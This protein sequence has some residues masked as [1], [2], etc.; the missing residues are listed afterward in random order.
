MMFFVKIFSFRFVHIAHKC[1]I[2]I[3]PPVIFGVA[4]PGQV[5]YF[6]TIKQFSACRFCLLSC[7]LSVD[8]EYNDIPVTFPP[9]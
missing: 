9:T 4:I 1:K 5:E 8:F 2:N 3:R 7:L 6:L